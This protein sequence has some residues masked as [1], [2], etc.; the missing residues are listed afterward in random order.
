MKNEDDF[1]C[2]IC[3]CLLVD[4]V[5]GAER[6]VMCY[7]CATLNHV[8]LS[9]TLSLTVCLSLVVGVCGHDFCLACYETWVVEQQKLTC[10]V[11]RAFLSQEVPGTLAVFLAA[12]PLL[13]KDQDGLSL[14]VVSDREGRFDL[15]A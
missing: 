3:L 8:C 15:Y 10:P 14:G 5:V 11:C 7:K 1:S 9:L 4:P 6:L 12:S 2:P 13:P